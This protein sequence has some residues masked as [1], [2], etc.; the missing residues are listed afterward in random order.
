M[1]VNLDT[2]LKLY[3][4]PSQVDNTIK[5]IKKHE[6]WIEFLNNY[7]YDGQLISSPYSIKGIVENYYNNV[8]VPSPVPSPVTVT[9]PVPV[10]A[11]T[12]TS[13]ATN[14]LKYIKEE[15]RDTGHYDRFQDANALEKWYVYND[16]NGK[17]ID[18]KTK[19][20][21]GKR[22][23][24]RNRKSKKSRKNRRKSNRRR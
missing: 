6:K 23:S 19:L 8:P 22:K 1:S 9:D 16:A 24:R 21:G 12:T 5:L 4:T 11:A 7:K 15:Y 2:T 18:S 3:G 13:S 17:Q 14:G 20:T 10:P